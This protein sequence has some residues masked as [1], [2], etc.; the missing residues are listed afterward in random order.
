[1]SISVYFCGNI[2]NKLILLLLIFLLLLLI[3][4]NNK[5]TWCFHK[6]E[7]IL[8]I[9]TQ[10]YKDLIKFIFRACFSKEHA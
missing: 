6:T 4:T 3:I 1:M 10:T 2:N 5:F 9:T 7:L 8:M